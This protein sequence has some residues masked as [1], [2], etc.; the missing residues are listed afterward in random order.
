MANSKCSNVATLRPKKDDE[1]SEAEYRQLDRE[2]NGIKCALICATHALGYAQD[3]EDRELGS[4][5]W[6][7]IRECTRRLEQFEL[8]L[9][10][11]WV[12]S[13][14]ISREVANG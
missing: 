9:D 11:F 5:A 7:S 8:A 4:Q 6:R 13:T 10:N 1:Q 3:H 12:R 2:I 14:V